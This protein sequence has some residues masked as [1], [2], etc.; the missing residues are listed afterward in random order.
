MLYYI[1]QAFGIVALIIM[2]LSYQQKTRSG[3]LQ[4]QI[5]SNLFFMGSY[6][7]LGA[8]TG[9]IMSLINIARSFVFSKRHTQWGKSRIW[10]YAFLIISMIAGMITWGGFDSIFSI[11]GTLLITVALYSESPKRMRLLL[12]PCPFLYFVYN[13]INHSLGGIGS[14]IFCLIS[15]AVAI[16]RFD[17][18]KSGSGE[19]KAATGTAPAEPT[20][21]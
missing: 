19:D 1:A 7:L 13:I 18:R 11:A 20:Q 2:V 4:F 15:A 14:D 21:Q 3:L 10:L 9:F 16:W 17:I 6:Y 5:I 8:Y 12:L